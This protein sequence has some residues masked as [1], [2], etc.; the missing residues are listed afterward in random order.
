MRLNMQECLL[1]LLADGETHSGTVI[2]DH[3]GVSRTAVWKH[4]RQMADLGLDFE[5]RAGSG[6]RLARPIEMLNKAAIV[7]DLPTAIRENISALDVLWSI[8]STSDRLLE[9]EPPPPGS[10]AKSPFRCFRHPK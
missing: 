3:I 8:G 7:A 9:Q 6:Y 10:S 5:A 1:R 4:L 2:A